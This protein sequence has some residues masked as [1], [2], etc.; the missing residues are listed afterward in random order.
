MGVLVGSAGHRACVLLMQ[1]KNRQSFQSKDD[2]CKQSS[3]ADQ[4]SHSTRSTSSPFMRA[5]RRPRG[6]ASAELATLPAR[7]DRSHIPLDSL[8]SFQTC[9]GQDHNILYCHQVPKGTGPV[10]QPLQTATEPTRASLEEAGAP[11]WDTGTHSTLPTSQV[12]PSEG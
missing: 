1:T 12:P 7:L 9:S 2:V 5:G 11:H 3:P 10:R 6:K 8:S 4:T